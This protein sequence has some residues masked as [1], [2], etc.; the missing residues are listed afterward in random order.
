[1]Q[2]PG[3]KAYVIARVCAGLSLLHIARREVAHV[4]PLLTSGPVQQPFFSSGLPWPLYS[5]CQLNMPRARTSSY[6]AAICGGRAGG[7]RAGAWRHSAK[8]HAHGAPRTARLRRT[9]LV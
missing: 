6:T 9:F 8:Q 1:M 5:C 7:G 4:G 3:E 2:R